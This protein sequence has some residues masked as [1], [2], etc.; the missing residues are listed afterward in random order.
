MVFYLEFSLVSFTLC[1]IGFG[2]GGWGGREIVGMGG[3]VP[4]MTRAHPQFFRGQKV[5]DKNYIYTL[6]S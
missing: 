1:C 6:K 4:G 2:E 3:R 5:G